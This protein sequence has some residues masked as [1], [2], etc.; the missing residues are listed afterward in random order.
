M[1]ALDILFVR[2]WWE[3]SADTPDSFTQFYHWFNLAEGTAWLIFAV[4]VFWRFC[5]QRKSS[6]EVFYALLFLTFGLSD[7]REAWIQTSWLIWLKLFNLLALFSVRR[8]VMRQ[9][10]PD[11]KLF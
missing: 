4:L 7:I 5:T 2:T 10:Y 11:A 1:D 6:V 8:R 9:C 3:Y